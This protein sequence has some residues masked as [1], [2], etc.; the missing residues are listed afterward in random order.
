MTI[1]INNVTGALLTDGAIAV[2]NHTRFGAKCYERERFCWALA[3]RNQSREM[4]GATTAP[5]LLAAFEREASTR[6]HDVL[7]IMY[8][9]QVAEQYWIEQ[10][11][12]G[13]CFLARAV[14]EPWSGVGCYRDEWSRYFAAH[15]DA[16]PQ[17]V[18]EEFIHIVNVLNGL[19]DP[20]DAGPQIAMCDLSALQS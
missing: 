4:A 19:L 12:D 13:P 15:R 20:T 3:G 8:P 11:K 10:K 18:A 16:D 9:D 7:V 2:E 14:L 17:S 5:D 1:I 6:T